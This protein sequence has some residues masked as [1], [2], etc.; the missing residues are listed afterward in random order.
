MRRSAATNANNIGTGLAERRISESILSSNCSRR[1]VRGARCIAFAAP[2]SLLA[3]ATHDSGAG[4]V[5]VTEPIAGRLIERDDRLVVVVVALGQVAHL[6][7][8]LLRHRDQESSVAGLGAQALEAAQQRL[9]VGAVALPQTNAG[10]VAQDDR[11]AKRDNAHPSRGSR[12]SV[13]SR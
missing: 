9:P 3:G 13:N 10:P 11:R 7:L 12:T 2:P 1:S 5:A 4:D 8:A 6:L